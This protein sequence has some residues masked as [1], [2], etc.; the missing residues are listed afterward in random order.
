[1]RNEK[2]PA[3]SDTASATCPPEQLT[4]IRAPATGALLSFVARPVIAVSPC[5]AAA[6]AQSPQSTRSAGRNVVKRGMRRPDL[7]S[8]RPGKSLLKPSDRRRDDQPAVELH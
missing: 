6:T 4:E 5:S 3:W 2:R 7:L 8:A 1:M